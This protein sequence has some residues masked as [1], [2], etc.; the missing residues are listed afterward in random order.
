MQKFSFYSFT[1]HQFFYSDRISCLP[2]VN[3]L[4]FILIS[5]P[6][7]RSDIT[8]HT[9][10]FVDNYYTFHNVDFA[11]QFQFSETFYKFCSTELS[12]KRNNF[13]LQTKYNSNFETAFSRRKA[14]SILRKYVFAQSA[15]KQTPLGIDAFWDKTT[16]DP[17]L[18]RKNVGLA[19]LAKKNIILDT[20]FGLKQSTENEL[21]TTD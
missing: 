7:A 17:P 13:F 10:Y 19:V 21:P 4:L 5:F 2:P 14:D 6:A 20:L 3:C 9:S 1:L 16:P 8:V 11:I 18:Q 15:K 12:S